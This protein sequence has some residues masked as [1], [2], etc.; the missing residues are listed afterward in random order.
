MGDLLKFSK[1]P[2]IRCLAL[3]ILLT[4]STHLE[5]LV[6]AIYD[7]DLWWH[8]RDGD[9]IIAQHA[10]PHHGV[11]SQYVNLPWAAYSWGFEVI[12]S[13]FYHWF[14]LAGFVALRSGLEVAITA[15]LFVILLRGSGRFWQAWALTGA[16]MWAM[17]HCLGLQPMLTSV[18]MF[19]IE[20]GL[21]VE[22]QRRR[23]IR[24][25]FL[26]PILFLFWANLHIHFIYG[27]FVLGLVVSVSIGR[28]LLPKNWTASLEPERPLPVAGLAAVGVLSALATLIGPYSWRLYGVV[29]SYMGSKAPYSL[30][31]ELQALDFRSTEHFIVLLIVAGAF[32]SLGW[33]RCR[34]PI[35]LVLLVA[36]TLL[37]FRMQRDSWLVCIPALA[38]IAERKLATAEEAVV[39]R[40]R[41]W[42][43][44]AVTAFATLLVLLMTAWDSKVDN[45]SLERALA[46]YFPVRACEFVRKATFPVPIYN[47][48]NWGG[49]LIWSLPGY[50]VAIDG[51]TDLYGDEV[52]TRYSRVEQGAPQWSSDPDLLA[53]RLVLLDRRTQ[54][55]A[56]LYHDPRFQLLYEDPLAVVFLRNTR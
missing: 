40:A 16:G 51:R 46:G 12:V 3:V 2:T 15:L 10:V 39:S 44:A 14:G 4:G 33:Q 17:H 48:M 21:I 11:F 18:L 32:F 9:A 19:T 38:F 43:F 28:A 8:L 47:N 23:E 54:L 31:V 49:F 56:L 50:P 52:L 13:R 26:M 36:C 42:T 1:R 34:D 29:L 27:L 37:S 25:L 53:S 35:K 20:I 30:I 6:S 45:P 22:A 24:L 41:A 7:P 5:P 55:A